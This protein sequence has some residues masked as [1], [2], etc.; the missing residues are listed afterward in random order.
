MQVLVLVLVLVVVPMLVEAWIA[1]RHERVQLSRGGVQPEGDVYAVLQVAYP[2]AFLAMI[3]EG[4]L[5]GAPPNAVVASG[6]ATFALAK[7]LKWWAIRS[8]GD[9]WT[10]RVIVVPGMTPVTTGPYRWLRHP[11]YV[12]VVGELV[13]AALMAGALIAGPICTLGFGALMLRRIRVEES[14][15]QRFA[16]PDGGSNRTRP[17]SG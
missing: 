12:A 4:T 9:C 8:L 2:A 17:T 15:F 7:T 14:A 3:V 10:F 5:R 13:G 1:R 6:L 11:N 16:T